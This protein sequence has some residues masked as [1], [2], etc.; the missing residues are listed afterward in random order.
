MQLCARIA[1]AR[2][3]IEQT[4]AVHNFFTNWL[5]SRKICGAAR[6]GDLYNILKYCTPAAI[7]FNIILINS[8]LSLA[9]RWRRPL[10]RTMLSIQ[11]KNIQWRRKRLGSFSRP[12]EPMFTSLQRKKEIRASVNRH[13]ISNC[14]RRHKMSSGHVGHV[15][16]WRVHGKPFS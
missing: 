10:R 14:H 6:M 12:L 8:N 11:H 16:Q 2:C 3:I 15:R 7:P 5:F 9:M 1:C 13:L 4:L